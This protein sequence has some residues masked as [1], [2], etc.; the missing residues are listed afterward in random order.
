MA[1]EMGRLRS[2]VLGVFKEW[3]TG[4]DDAGRCRLQLAAVHHNRH[5]SMTQESIAKSRTPARF[6]SPRFPNVGAPPAPSSLNPN[7]PLL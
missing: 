3:M 4:R 5:T 1:T 7:F 6:I 2:E